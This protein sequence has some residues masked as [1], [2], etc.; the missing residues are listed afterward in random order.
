MVQVARSQ[1]ILGLGHGLKDGRAIPT[2]IV[3]M[4]KFVP[5]ALKFIVSQNDQ[6]APQ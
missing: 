3:F 1:K 5:F 6:N 2:L 4:I